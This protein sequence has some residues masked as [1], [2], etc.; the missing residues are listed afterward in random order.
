[1][2]VARGCHS[3]RNGEAISRLAR[4]TTI[5]WG[6]NDFMATAAGITGYALPATGAAEDSVNIL[7]ELLGMAG[8]GVRQ[9]E[10]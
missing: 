8:K 3:W 9:C 10:C 1:M 5:S 7:P 6:L 4:S 2:K